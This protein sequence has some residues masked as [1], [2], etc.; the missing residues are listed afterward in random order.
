MIDEL[1]FYRAC[2]KRGIT[3]C[4]IP[5][6]M[7]EEVSCW[8][9]EKCPTFRDRQTWVASHTFDSSDE[10]F[11]AVEEYFAKGVEPRKK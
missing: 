4:R 8:L 11:A 6:P 10:M 9:V 5:K 1:S 2:C 7:K 3:I